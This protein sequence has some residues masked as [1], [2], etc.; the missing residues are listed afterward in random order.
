MQ[1]VSLPLRRLGS[2]TTRRL[3]S[4]ADHLARHTGAEAVVLF[5]SRARGDAS[6][7]SDWDLCVILPDDVLPGRYN[8]VDLW[9]EVSEFDLPVQIYPIRRSVFI[10]RASDVNSVSHDILRDGQS[11]VGS[12]DFARSHENPA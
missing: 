10:S 2:D 1:E 11:I 3:Q 9:R 5:G 4:V 6:R 7:S 12:L 8:A